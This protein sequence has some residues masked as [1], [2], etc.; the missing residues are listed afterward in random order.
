MPVGWWSSVAELRVSGA[1]LDATLVCSRAQEENCGT[2]L[3][4]PNIK[5]RLSLARAPPASRAFLDQ[6]SRAFLDQRRRVHLH[7]V[8]SVPR[9]R[10]DM[11][12][13]QEFLQQ[14]PKK[15]GLSKLRL[16]VNLV[17]KSQTFVS[18][19]RSCRTSDLLLQSYNTVAELCAGTG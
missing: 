12:S 9:C 19:L 16:A 17:S 1:P 3:S 15:V 11:S 8:A 5:R 18:K 4:A 13:E 10:P 14:T 7:P 6:R 2:C